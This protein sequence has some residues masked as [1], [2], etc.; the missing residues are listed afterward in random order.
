M[1]ETA[2]L[3]QYVIAGLGQTGLSCVRYLL[4]QSVAFKVWDTRA[5]YTVGEEL[6]ARVNADITCGELPQNYWQGVTHLV[7]S[8]GIATDLPEVARAR[9]AGVSVI[10]DIELFAL[11]VKQPVIGITGSNGKTTV[12][13]LTTHI[14]QQLGFNAVAAGNVGLPALDSLQQAA[15]VTVLELSSFQLETTRSLALWAGTILN[16]SADHLDRHHTLAAYSEAKQ[17][18]FDHCQVAVVNREDSNTMPMTAVETKIATGLNPASEDFGWD[19][20]GQTITYNGKPLLALADTALVGLHN[21]LN[22]QSA[23]ALVSVF[24]QDMTAA[25]QAVKSF[26][27]APHRCTKIADVAGVSFIDDSKAT[28]IGATEAALQGLAGSVT[29]KL[30]LIAGGD[31]KGADL[32]ELAPA[33]TE[34][35]DVV[36]ALGKDGQVLSDIAEQGYYVESLERAV[37]QAFLLAKPGDTVLLSPACASLDMFNNYQHRAEVF[38]QAVKELSA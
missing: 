13:L 26:K 35:V 24:S 11:A 5:D 37:Q 29:G 22:I 4:Q 10:G 33:L 17:R 34:H 28:N 19:A 12:T 23:L 20:A 31:A 16:I 36:I 2:R 21:A 7:L 30:L 1:T 6:A 8:P 14:L 32:S 25:A 15:D 38:Q 9:Q 3:P 18:I 27:S